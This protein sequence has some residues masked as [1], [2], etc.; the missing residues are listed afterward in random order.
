MVL[1]IQTLGGF[2]A[3]REELTMTPGLAFF[4]MMADYVIQVDGSMKGM[5]EVL[6]QKARPVI[7]MSRTDTSRGRLLQH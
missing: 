1:G 2:E 5:G 4:D 7:Y 6:L 3:N